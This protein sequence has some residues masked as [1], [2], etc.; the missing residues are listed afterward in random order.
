MDGSVLEEKSSFKILGL[1][2]SSKLDWGSYN[3][4]NAKTALRKN[5]ALIHSMKPLSP[6][7]I[8]Y[9]INLSYNHAWNI[10]MSGL[11]FLVAT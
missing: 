3:I 6:E 7:V 2:F 9:L 4:S 5:G 10:V 11:V 8:L 1:T